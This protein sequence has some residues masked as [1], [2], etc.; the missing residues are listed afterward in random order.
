MPFWC[1]CFTK[2]VC[3]LCSKSLQC[4]A[5]RAETELQ[6]LQ[7]FLSMVSLL[8]CHHGQ[9]LLFSDIIRQPYYPYQIAYLI[10]LPVFASV[11]S[12]PANQVYRPWAPPGAWCWFEYDGSCRGAAAWDFRRFCRGTWVWRCMKE[13][14]L[15]Q[16]ASLADYFTNKFRTRKPWEPTEVI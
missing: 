10:Y 9:C 12:S 11:P 13:M 8:L 2:I 3:A 14:W 7:F 4:R 5:Q 1:S 15:P 6:F 16:W